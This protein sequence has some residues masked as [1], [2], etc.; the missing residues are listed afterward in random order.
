MPNATRS[1]F[2]MTG[3]TT[4]SYTLSLH[5]ALPIW[6]EAAAVCTSA[7]WCSSRMVP[8]MPS[9]EN[10]TALDRKST[11]LNSSHVRIS[12]AVFC[13]KKK[14]EDERNRRRHGADAPVGRARGVTALC[15][16]R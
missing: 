1:F 4:E 7:V 15:R 14:I 3:T 5:D 13:W 16:P 9:A 6:F 8:V 11:R 12:Y 2:Y 10:H